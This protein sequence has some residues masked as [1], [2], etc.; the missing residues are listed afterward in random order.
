MAGSALLMLTALKRFDSPAEPV[1]TRHGMSPLLVEAAKRGM[2]L[3][4]IG[5]RLPGNPGT[6]E[7]ALGMAAYSI[8]SRCKGCGRAAILPPRA[9]RRNS[10][11]Q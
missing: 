11:A 3:L 1:A 5:E 6:A 7:I 10:A 9:P 4:E 8:A 2:I